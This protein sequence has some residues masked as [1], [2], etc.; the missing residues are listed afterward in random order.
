MSSPPDMDAFLADPSVLAALDNLEREHQRGVD[1]AG[2]APRGR[3][4]GGWLDASK[5]QGS[6]FRVRVAAVVWLVSSHVVSFLETS[7]TQEVVVVEHH[8]GGHAHGHKYN[9]RMVIFFV[10]ASGSKEHNASWGKR[11]TRGRRQSYLT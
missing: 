1:P 2:G 6:H 3:P 5:E 7:S 8:R 4:C 11:Y 9:I 10:S